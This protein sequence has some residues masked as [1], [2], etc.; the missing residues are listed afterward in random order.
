[1]KKSLFLSVLVF[2]QLIINAEAQNWTLVPSPTTNNLYGVASRDSNTW[3]AV[4]DIGTIIRSTN[5]GSSWT[6]VSSPAADALRAVSF[7][8]NIGIAVGIGGL[9]LRTTDGGLNWIKET[10]PTT[11][12]L[13]SVSMTSQ[14]AVIGGEEGTILV[15]TDSGLNWTPHTAGTAAVLFGMTVIGDVGIGSGGQGD[16]VLSNQ[17]GV[18]WSLTVIGTLN[19]FFYGISFATNK[20]GWTVG[21]SS[22]IGSI[23]ARSNSSGFTWTSQTSPVTDILFGVSAIDTSNVTA[24][25]GNG[26]IIHTVDGGKVWTVQPSGITEILN[27]VSFVKPKFGIAVGNGGR[28]LKTTSVVSGVAQISANKNNSFLYP[29]PNNGTF[30][31]KSEAII[32]EV[33]ILNMIGEVIFSR[34]IQSDYSKI[35]LSNQPCGIYYYKLKSNHAVLTAGEFVIER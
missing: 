11:K 19:T 17:R 35:D 16:I 20:I 4:G 21:T 28:I 22:T 2:F 15:S 27:A 34:H 12:P 26:S 8:G 7:N 23:I 9:V 30:F 25:G 32:S 13:Y 29:N 10:K 1:M 24:V 31:V 33:E 18:A 14:M 3:I 5:G 6:S